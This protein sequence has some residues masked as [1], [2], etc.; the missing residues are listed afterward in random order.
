MAK[1][2]WIVCAMDGNVLAHPDTGEAETFSTEKA[3][4]KRA[5]EWVRN[6]EDVE[7]WVYC[8]SH[9]VARPDDVIV[10]VVK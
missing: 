8:L 7:A 6:S 4:I 3:A 1:K 9:V 5:T 2:D 10:T